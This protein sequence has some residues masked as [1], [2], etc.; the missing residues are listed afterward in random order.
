MK[1]SLVEE[2]SNRRGGGAPGTEKLRWEGTSGDQ[3][4]LLKAGPAS[5]DCSNLCPAGF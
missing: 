1:S 4:P 5:A 3:C 2:K